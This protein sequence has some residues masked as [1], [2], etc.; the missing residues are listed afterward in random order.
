MPYTLT[1]DGDFFQVADFIKG[2]DSL[3]KTEN[4]KVAVDGRLLTVNGFSLAA[5]AD[6]ASFPALEATLLRHHLP[7]PARAGRD[8]RRDARPARRR[9]TRRRP[10]RPPGGAP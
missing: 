7:D 3:V 9:P 6:E 8:R 5:D 2:L 1:F 10:R 4:E